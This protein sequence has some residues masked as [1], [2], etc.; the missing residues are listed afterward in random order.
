MGI[1]GFILIVIGLIIGL[2]FGIQLL[3]LAFKASPWWKATFITLLVSPVL[4]VLAFGDST[5]SLWGYSLLPIATLVFVITHWKEAKTPFLRGI[6][7]IPFYILRF[8]LMGRS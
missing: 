8:V 7:A 6:I 3:M 4:L 2:I 1:L 5:L